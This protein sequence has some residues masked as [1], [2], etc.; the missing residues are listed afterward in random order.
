VKREKWLSVEMES[1]EREISDESNS[2]LENG[3][4]NMILIKI[5]HNLSFGPLD[6]ILNN[7][8]MQKQISN[9]KSA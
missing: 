4:E 7:L 3:E 2:Q 9:P 1:V 6:Q 8:G 5:L